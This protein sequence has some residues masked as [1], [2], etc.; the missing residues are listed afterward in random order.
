MIG[1]SITQIVAK[2]I[3]IAYHGEDHRLCTD[4]IAAPKSCRLFA[5]HTKNASK[6]EDVKDPDVFGAQVR[7]SRRI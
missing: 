5:M 4:Q 1:L 7:C 3:I 2:H 6:E